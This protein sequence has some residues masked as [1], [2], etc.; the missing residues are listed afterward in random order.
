MENKTK[1][2]A[3]LR[4]QKADYARV[5]CDQYSTVLYSDSTVRTVLYST[6]QYENTVRYVQY[7]NLCGRYS[8]VYKSPELGVRVIISSHLVPIQPTI[9]VRVCTSVHQQQ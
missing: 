5:Y 6:V 3:I 2:A 4:Q 7:L 8:K 1:L 9:A